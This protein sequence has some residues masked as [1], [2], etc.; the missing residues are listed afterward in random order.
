MQYDYYGVTLMSGTQYEIQDLIIGSAK[1]DLVIYGDSITEG[2]AYYPANMLNTHWVQLIINKLKGNAVASGRSGT[3][4]AALMER[5]VNEI[6]FIK[7][8]YVMVT[9]GTNG[10]NTVSGLSNMVEYIQSQGAECILNHIPANINAGGISNHIST[11]NVIDEVREEYGLKGADFDIA[12]SINRNPS[13][14]VNQDM[15]WKEDYGG[16]TGT[17]Y[18]HPNDLGSMAMMEQIEIDIPFIFEL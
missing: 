1:C 14:G 11:N 12:T 13:E 4:M 2:E 10:G 16:S 15:M 8:K 17:V 7:P 6:P 3:A 18:H 9:I 5:I